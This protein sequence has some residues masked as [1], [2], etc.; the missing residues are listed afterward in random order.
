[1]SRFFIIISILFFFTVPAIS[2]DIR[3]AV[4]DLSA[5]NVPDF[6][7][8]TVRDRVE[9]SLYK[10]NRIELLERNK[11][12]LVLKEHNLISSACKD[13]S[14]A[15]QIGRF[16]SATHVIVGNVTY[17]D[18]YTITLRVV[19]VSRGKI[20][21][22]DSESVPARP[23]IVGASTKIA[24]RI[25]EHIEGIHSDGSLSSKH[26]FILSIGGGYVQPIGVFSRI[27][28]G[29]YSVSLIGAVNNVGVNNLYLGIK[30]GFNRFWGKGDVNY[31]CIVPFTA[32]IGYVFNLPGSFFISPSLSAGGA[33]NYVNKEKSNNRGVVEPIINPGITVGYRI[34][35]NFSIVIGSDYHAIFERNVVIQLMT[36]NCCVSFSFIK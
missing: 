14:C 33:W 27:A 6:Y 23:Q 7:A 34:T 35:P 25:L 22:A 26:P 11:V 1:M 12:Q 20:V 24:A 32:L 5:V 28:R 8:G 10:S 15:V 13:D 30:G 4:L 3:L 21:Y 9:V 31:S 36:F 2:A 17:L 16:L 18:T 29:G 19:D